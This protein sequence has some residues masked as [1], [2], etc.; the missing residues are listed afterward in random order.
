MRCLKFKPAKKW[1]QECCFNS[2]LRCFSI[3]NGSLKAYFSKLFSEFKKKCLHLQRHAYAVPSEKDARTER[4]TTS[5]KKRHRCF[6]C[7]LFE[8]EKLKLCVKDNV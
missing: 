7:W 8:P 6:V 5:C 4:D 2:D 3:N 1:L